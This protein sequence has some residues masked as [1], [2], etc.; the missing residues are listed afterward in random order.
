MKHILTLGMLFACL[1]MTAQ[2]V[3]MLKKTRHLDISIEDDNLKILEKN[4]ESK[5]FLKNV[6]QYANDAIFY[7]SMEPLVEFEAYTKVPHKKGKYKDKEVEIVETQDIVSPG[8]FYGGYQ[9]KEFVFPAVVPDA[10]SVLN[11]TQHN[12]DPHLLGSFFFDAGYPT[13]E[14]AFSVSFPTSVAI[15]YNLFH[16]E[17]LNLTH[18]IDT[19]GKIITHSWKGK[20]ID[21]RAYNQNAPSRSYYS[22][23]II[24]RINS[25]EAA[26]KKVS[27]SHSTDDLFKWYNGLIHQIPDDADLTPLQEKV[28]S[29]TKETKSPKEI[30]E[31]LYQ[32]VQSNIKYVAFED[33]M[34]G[35]IPRSAGDVYAKKYGDCKDMANILTTM[36]NF[37]EVPA[38]LTWIGTND[39]PY[40][41]HDVP[42]TMTDNHMICAVKENGEYVFLDPTNSYLIYG[43]SPRLVQGKEA[44]IR[45][46]DDNY[47]IVKVPISDAQ[48]NKRHDKLE[49]TIDDVVLKGN[50]ETVLEGYCRENYHQEKMY[51]EYN[52]ETNF[53]QNYLLLGKNSSK[54][55]NT[56]VQ[57]EKEL[58]NLSFEGH[59]K[60]DIIKAGSK[61]YVNLNLDSSSEDYLI[62][63]LST[64]IYPIQE[65]FKHTYVYNCTLTIPEGYSID[66]LPENKNIDSENCQF[67]STYTVKGK[68]ITYDKIIVSNYLLLEKDNFKEYETFFAELLKTN[69]QKITL[70][71]TSDE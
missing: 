56:K 6:T 29:L 25:F 51:G 65:D 2:E 3:V 33:G 26:G 38:Y 7:S 40:S 27:V 18:T 23:H 24:L 15:D 4:H 41:Y 61:L 21:K 16:T 19:V 30:T 50:V 32:W 71:V 57:E 14:T 46:D 49:L 34:A 52:Q 58:V 55:L 1:A 69:Q 22:P 36:L 43:D 8:I 35:F 31:K 53:M 66:F 44:L 48:Q 54:Y 10:I 60:N 13:N 67:K 12:T 59:F 9:K 63:D 11:Y 42:C 68:T 20:D 17:Q 28:V 47:D 45:V 70:K 37:A 5:K 62:E 64:R 39:R